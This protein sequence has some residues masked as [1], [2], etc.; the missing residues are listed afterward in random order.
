MYYR[1]YEKNYEKF[2]LKKIY[3]DDKTKYII[4]Y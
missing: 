2:N 1:N 3:L 4:F